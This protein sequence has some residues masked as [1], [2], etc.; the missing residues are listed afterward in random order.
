[1]DCK[2]NCAAKIANFFEPHRDKREYYLSHL[3][4]VEDINENGNSEAQRVAQT[5]MADVHTA[6]KMG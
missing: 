6:M 1:M 2:K 3:S 5:T 4:E